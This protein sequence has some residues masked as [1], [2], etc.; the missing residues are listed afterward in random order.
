MN[1][2]TEFYY[3]RYYKNN[4]ASFIIMIFSQISSV[5]T[6]LSLYK[7]N[8]SSKDSLSLPWLGQ[9]LFRLPTEIRYNVFLLL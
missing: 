4:N 1:I 3:H 8:H 6:V 9:E 7:D 5:D 2:H